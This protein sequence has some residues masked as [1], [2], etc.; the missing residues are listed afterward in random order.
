MKLV[1]P[2]KSAQHF[3]F[4]KG[5]CS[6]DIA[7]DGDRVY[8]KVVKKGIF[9]RKCVL[10]VWKLG[11]EKWKP[12]AHPEPP[13]RSAYDEVLI[14]VDDNQRL[15]LQKE[16]HSEK[17]LSKDDRDWNREQTIFIAKKAIQRNRRALSDRERQASLDNNNVDKV[18]DAFIRKNRES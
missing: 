13:T 11:L 14:E 12:S 7:Q 2:F 4:W 10:M 5:G 9:F 1:E 16:A 17:S 8:Y 15:Q 3:F 18:I 6:N